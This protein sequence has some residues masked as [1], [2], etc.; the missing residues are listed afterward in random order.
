M[1]KNDPNR[2]AREQQLNL[3]K[4]KAFKLA[5][6]AEGQERIGHNAF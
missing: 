6:V 2:R 4:Q 3:A 5:Q 1:D